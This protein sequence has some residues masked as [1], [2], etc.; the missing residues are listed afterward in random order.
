M[1]EGQIMA[2]KT[3]DS[4][5]FKDAVLSRNARQTVAHTDIIFKQ[6]QHI[7][8]RSLGYD[9]LKINKNN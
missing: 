7:D 2:F 6:S 8:L 4:N 3:S 9:W 1:I 5:K